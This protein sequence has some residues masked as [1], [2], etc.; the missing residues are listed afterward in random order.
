[1]KTRTIE[2]IIRDLEAWANAG[3]RYRVCAV[4]VGDD[5]T[6]DGITAMFGP[7]ER[8]VANLA[9][10]FADN[11]TSML[12]LTEQAQ[13]MLNDYREQ[14][15]SLQDTIDSLTPNTPSHADR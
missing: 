14:R 11:S 1:M 5:M 3:P 2:D 9:C 13:K 10:A 7:R 15:V 4:I 8:L 12:H 6:D